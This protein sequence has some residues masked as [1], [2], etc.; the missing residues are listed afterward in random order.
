MITHFTKTNIGYSHI[1]ENKP[2]QDYSASYHDEE[3]TIVTACDGHGGK[4]YIRSNVGSRYASNAIISVLQGV[5][6]SIF[7]RYT[8]Q[9]ICDKL[10]LQILCEWNALV[11]RHLGEK[12]FCKRELV[13]L[14]DAEIFKLKQNPAR[15]YGTTLQG[16][17]IFGNKLICVSLGDGGVFL[18]RKGEICTAFEEDEDKRGYLLLNG[19]PFW[20]DVVY[21]EIYSRARHSIY[22]VDNYIGLRTLEKLIN[23]PKGVAVS[24]FSDNLG[25][26]CENTYLDFCKEYPDISVKL[27][28][29]GGIFHDSYIILDYDTADEKVFLCGGSSKDAGGKITSILEDKDRNK[30][31]SLI[32]ELLKNEELKL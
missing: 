4:T 24:I 28:K 21:D 22:I 9:E 6:K 23:I 27:Y 7:Y 11:E 13:G 8:R 3:R 26:M 12:G 14:S 19:K 5:D 15:A 18:V 31:Q 29:S 32:K 17:M 25:K 30:Y 2:C 20:G 10:R 1:K 16:A